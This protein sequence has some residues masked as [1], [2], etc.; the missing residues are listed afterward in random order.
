MEQGI[1]KCKAIDLEAGCR[2]RRPG[3]SIFF[4]ISEITKP[5][6]SEHLVMI[7]HDRGT[8]YLANDTDVEAFFPPAV[9]WVGMIIEKRTEFYKGAC[10]A[11]GVVEDAGELTVMH[12]QHATPDQVKIVLVNRTLTQLGVDRLH[13]LFL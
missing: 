6:G 10:A 8:V 13:W 1:R 4:L 7:V 11:L 2:Y 3:G 12:E 9:D 5:G